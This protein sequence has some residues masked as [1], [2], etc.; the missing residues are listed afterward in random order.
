[1]RYFTI[2]MKKHFFS[3]ACV[4]LVINAEAQTL[5]S[6]LAQGFKRFSGNET[7]KYAAIGFT[8]QDAAGNTV[9][10]YQENM[11]LA[12]ASCQKIV[13]AATAFDQLGPEFRFATQIGYSGTISNGVLNGSL[14]VNGSG[15][16]TMASWRY[17]S[18]PDTAFFAQALQ[19]LKSKGI[20][21]INGDV[22]ATNSKYDM[23]AVPGGWI[24]DD[25]GNYYGAGSW[26]LN[27]HENQFDAL[28][29]AN[30]KQ[31]DAATLQKIE[32][33]TVLNSFNNFV[34]VGAAGTGDNSVI[35]S[36]PYSGMAYATGSLGKSEKPYTI[37]GAIP[38]G[39]A[40]L[41]DAL[42]NY[43]TANDI[44]IQ[45]D[46]KSSQYFLINKKPMPKSSET[47]GTYQS[48]GLDS[49]AY[50]FLQKSINL[51]GE[52]LLKNLAIAAGKIGNTEIAAD[53]ER[54][55]WEAKGIDRNALKVRDGSGLSPQNRVTSKSLVQILQYAKKQKWYSAY[56][57]A[58]PLIHNIKMKSGTISGAKGYTGYITD[59][60]GR[61]YTFALLVNNYS[62]SANAVVQNMWQLLDI[63]VNNK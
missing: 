63:I 27:Y 28:F 38:N 51:Y 29:T 32:P 48:V 14:L 23:Q 15:D 37:G 62:G 12:P 11:G 55:Y 44:S 9:F 18:Q 30:G 35:Y 42:K 7:M 36:T 49:V 4:C 43:L 25:M 57:E 10:A 17:P 47:I 31:G 40:A 61:E 1:M 21:T 3:L 16:P 60:S 54:S 59:K 26:A 45:G 52:A 46:T 13:T 33:A 2:A 50:W 6:S 41:L 8:V 39:E 58:F 24:Y 19:A 56:Y 53:W 5:S 22:V 34:T 20:S